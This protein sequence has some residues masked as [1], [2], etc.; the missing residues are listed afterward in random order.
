MQA[1]AMKDD[2]VAFARRTAVNKQV[3]DYARSYASRYKS[4]TGNL[5]S[6]MMLRNPN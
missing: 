1:S 6:M 3:K 5:C 2:S 4:L